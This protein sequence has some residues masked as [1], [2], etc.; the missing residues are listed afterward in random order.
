MAALIRD[1]ELN[2]VI[3]TLDALHCQRE[4]AKRLNEAGAR[5]ALAL[6]TNQP[7]LHD[8]VALFMADPA[9]ATTVHIDVD[10]GH[11]RIETRLARVCTNVEWLQA[12]HDW[13]GLAALGA[14][15]RVR[16]T[17]TG[18]VRE[19]QLYLLGHAFSAAELAALSRGHW[20]IENRLHWVLDVSMG[21]DA[22]RARRDH[23]AENLATLRRL[24]LNAI[25]RLPGKRSVP[26][27][28]LDAMLETSKLTK[29]L[30]LALKS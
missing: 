13:P 18:T 10:G 5:Y 26:L 11:G 3:V 19:Q 21:E 20:G 25:R 14:V 22:C 17:R 23:A 28:M 24:A 12:E 30:N 4:T 7:S 15:E 1:M 2:G 16:E 9:T 6:K 29:L 8:D 27:I